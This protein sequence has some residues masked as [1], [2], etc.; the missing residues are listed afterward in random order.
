[1]LFKKPLFLIP[2][3]A[4]F[5]MSSASYAAVLPDERADLMMHSYDGGNV[6]VSGPAVLIRTNVTSNTSVFYNYY[7]DNI[8]LSL[9]HI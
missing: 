4:L 9:I 7:V 3:L 5:V 1:M 2:L 6:E 8:S